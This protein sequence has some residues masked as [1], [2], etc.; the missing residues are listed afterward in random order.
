[1]VTVLPPPPDLSRA[2]GSRLLYGFGDRAHD[3]G[4]STTKTHAHTICK[5]THDAPLEMMSIRPGKN[6][7][8]RR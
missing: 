8:L 4:Q 1:M 6:T 3:C 2:F 7:A 5:T